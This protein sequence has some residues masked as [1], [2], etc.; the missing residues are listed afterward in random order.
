M[1][2]RVPLIVASAWLLLVSSSAMAA[3]TRVAT[4][5][6]L[7]ASCCGAASQAGAPASQSASSPSAASSAAAPSAG[8][9]GES[10]P[11]QSS[12][13][14]SYADDGPTEPLAQAP[15]GETQPERARV[16]EQA[17][18][19]GAGAGRSART[20]AVRYLLEHQREDGSWGSR[21]PSVLELGYSREAYY[22]WMTASSALACMAL[23]SVPETPERRL[24][25][26]RGL[27]WLCTTRI[28]ARAS[29]WDVDHVW[30]ALYG[31]VA[32]VEL[33]GDERFAGGAWPALL[34]ER[35]LAF[36][37]ILERYQ[38]DTGGWA[39]YDDAPFLTQPTWATS[40]CT[41]LVIP[42]LIDA[43]ALGWPIPERELARALRY[44][45]RCALPGGAYAYDLTP[46][47]R[48][49]GVEHI[50]LI[51]GSLGRTQVCNW[52][53]VRGG[54]RRITTDVVR[55]GVESFFE[56]HAFL[57]H[58][59]TRP[60]PHEGFFANAGYFYFFAHYYASR[61]IELLPEQEREALHARLRAH[62]IGAQ[63]ASGGT[64]D[65][66][67]SPSYI[68]SSTSFLILALSLGL[69]SH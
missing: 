48:I 41:A 21:T 30:S 42:S 51:Q 57:E 38:A 4:P 10:S 34:R 14:A 53:L 25:L 50:N 2:L 31:F 58:V 12:A 61:A 11:S 9:T 64:N 8:S 7:A 43:R 28:P 15:S 26:E 1:K 16:S 66:V 60:I 6:P 68:A 32:C 18:R 62:L 49:S 67:D 46:V 55:E 13:S 35:G 44:V 47:T 69:D 54:V 5:L 36:H 20:L 22:A 27:R 17:A 3:T 24:A 63:W 39:Y 29:D 40:F 65:F 56:H 52:A 59:R 33:A 37:A 45:E 23:A 19:R